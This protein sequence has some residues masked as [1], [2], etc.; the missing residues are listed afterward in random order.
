M[1]NN[2]KKV[3]WFTGLSGSGKTTLGIKLRNYLS[4]KKYTCVFLDGDDLRAGL[5]SDL[6]F[7]QRDR[8]ENIRRVAEIAA[9]MLKQNDYVIV[10]TISPNNIIRN[11][12]RKIIGSNYFVLVYLSTSLSTCI[13]RDVK[14]HYKQALKGKIK[15]FTGIGAD[16][17]APKSFKL[18]IDTSILSINDS[19][20][21]IAKLID[22]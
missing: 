11:L 2:K 17:M 5:C 16:F 8:L 18:K 3:I 10:A 7:S 9:I 21:E 22:I 19:V 15:N 14:G 12:A 1:I 4:K 6:K 20:A 13:S